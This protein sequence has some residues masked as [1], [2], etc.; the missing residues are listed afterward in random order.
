LPNTAT[1]ALC[2]A[3][4]SKPREIDAPSYIFFTLVLVSPDNTLQFY[5][6]VKKDTLVEDSF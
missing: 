3:A 1:H 5:L 6:L 2:D 4:R